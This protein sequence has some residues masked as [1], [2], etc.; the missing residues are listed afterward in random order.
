MFDWGGKGKVVCLFVFL[1]IYFVSP[2]TPRKTASGYWGHSVHFFC[3]VSSKKYVYMEKS[4][5]FVDAQVTDE[6]GRD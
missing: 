5:T 3:M 1:F 4:Y 6:G 2:L